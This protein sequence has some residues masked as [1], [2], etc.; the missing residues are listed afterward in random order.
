M[1]LHLNVSVGLSMHACAHTYECAREGD[2]YLSEE[3]SVH[4][5]VHTCTHP[6]VS[7]LK[8]TERGGEGLKPQ[9]P[10]RQ[11]KIL[12]EGSNTRGSLGALCLDPAPPSSWANA[13]PL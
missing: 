2:V 13:S 4:T 1:Y 11:P 8:V 7:S 9:G 5:Y 10:S 6:T 3:V 12:D